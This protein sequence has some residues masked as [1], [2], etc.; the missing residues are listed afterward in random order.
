[1][2]VFVFLVATLNLAV[3]YAIGSGLIDRV[4]SPL[5]LLSLLPIGKKSQPLEI[6]DA[7][8]LTKPAAKDEEEAAEKATEKAAEEHA[9]EEAAP[10]NEK[11]KAKKD[12][13]AG[14]SDFREQLTAAS[15]ELKENQEDPEKFDESAGKMQKANHE[16][17]EQAQDAIQELDG[18]EGENASEARDAVA[19]GAEEVARISD[20]FDDLV[21][22][23]L[24]EESRA[25]LVECSESIVETTTEV[26][27]ATDKVQAEPESAEQA[28]E[29]KKPKSKPKDATKLPE[30]T[31]LLESYDELFDLLETQ[32]N[33]EE[34]DGSYQ[35]AAIRLDPIDGQDDSEA[36]A[37]IQESLL[38]ISAQVLSAGQPLASGESTF[39]L[40]NGDSHEKA[41]QRI[42][43]LRQLVAASTFMHGDDSIDATITCAV[44][45]AEQ[46]LD[47][48]ELKER[49]TQALD[50]SQNEGG[51]KTFHHD[52]AF[53]TAVEEIKSKVEK[54][55]VAV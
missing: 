45:E 36:L 30:P 14:L 15:I 22:G 42:E 44:A 54:Q 6:D 1:M 19:S 40:L 27:E 49:L 33:D 31:D 9:A 37:A 10:E 11:K 28:P 34:K 4:P 51:N 55:T 3:G 18:I 29:E 46:G 32:L 21:E 12:V 5:A 47:R 24:D 53:A 52:G 8:E 20:E 50:E 41:L 2:L 38:G 7:D 43:N 16:Y 13:L 48:K 17:L 39:L 23:G 35:V 26:A 25:K